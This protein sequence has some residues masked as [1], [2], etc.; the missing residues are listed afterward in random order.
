MH[1]SASGDRPDWAG[2]F[3]PA[4]LAGSHLR[5]LRDLGQP[6]K[7]L[8]FAEAALDLPVHNV[9]TRALHTALI[10]SVHAD[11]GNLDQACATGHEAITLT[12]Q[13]RSR[14]AVRRITDIT[15]RLANHH[16]NPAV[17]ELTDHANTLTT[18]Q[19]TI[20]T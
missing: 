13:L 1:A 11:L 16:D 6:A 14:R 12:T 15:R 2:F 19:T 18:T 8:G 20:A 4:H 3:S 9:R 5:C 10:A 7:A 17:K